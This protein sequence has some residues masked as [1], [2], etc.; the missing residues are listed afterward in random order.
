MQRFLGVVSFFFIGSIRSLGTKRRWFNPVPE[1]VRATPTQMPCRGIKP[2]L[3][4]MII[5]AVTAIT[6]YL[7]HRVHPVPSVRP[8]RPMNRGRGGFFF[9]GG[10]LRGV[11]GAAKVRQTASP[12]SGLATPRFAILALL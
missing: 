9:E 1:R 2:H 10:C 7:C 8:P 5:F 4:R 6:E 3:S 11:I 12:S